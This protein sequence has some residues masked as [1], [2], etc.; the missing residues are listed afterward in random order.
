MVLSTAGASWALQKGA[1]GSS[2]TSMKGTISNPP[3]GSGSALKGMRG[4]LNQ[5]KRGGLGVAKEAES[6]GEE[7]DE[8]MVADEVSELD[9]PPKD[10]D[11]AMDVD[12][13]RVAPW[14]PV[15]TPGPTAAVT[16]PRPREV[17]STNQQE[18]DRNSSQEASDQLH[19]G[20]IGSEIDRSTQ[21][22]TDERSSI[23]VPS[24]REVEGAPD[25]EVIR[26]FVIST[27]TIRFDLTSV[28][29]SW[30]AAVSSRSTSA[31]S[32]SVRTTASARIVQPSEI[33]SSAG[34]AEATLSRVVS[35]DDFERMEVL[36]QFNQAFVITRLCKPT[37]GHDDL[38]IV[39][40]H[41]ADEKYNFERLQIET[42]IETQKLIKWVSNLLFP[43]S[44]AFLPFRWPACL[45]ACGC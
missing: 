16:A 39:D 32:A 19:L 23:K 37:E 3:V 27:T 10:D 21:R 43:L 30:R 5:F 6:G 41:A 44:P 24:E 14:I 9:I 11:S 22:T 45:L 35:K 40:Q 17:I 42:R 20:R 8:E 28:E 31:T 15:T 18:Q 26:S 7:N 13:A 33:T 34:E 4:I 36:G 29:A 2:K 12:Q 38:F 25:D 1:G